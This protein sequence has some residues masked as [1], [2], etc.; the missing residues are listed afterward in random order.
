M[1]PEE[2]QSQEVI[3]SSVKFELEESDG[4]YSSQTN[5]ISAKRK[6]TR[7]RYQKKKAITQKR[8]EILDERAENVKKL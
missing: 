3:G 6:R 8:D 2:A 4:R 7:D 1:L 5:V